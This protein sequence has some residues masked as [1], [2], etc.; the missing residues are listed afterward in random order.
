MLVV[1]L[2]FRRIGDAGSGQRVHDGGCLLGRQ[3][4][5]EPGPRS[6]R[7]MGG[8]LWPMLVP[9]AILDR[10][11]AVLEGSRRVDHARRRQR[12]GSRPSLVASTVQQDHLGFLDRQNLIDRRA[13]VGR[14][15]GHLGVGN[16]LGPAGDPFGEIGERI[17]RGENRV[18]GCEK[19]CHLQHQF[20]T[21]V[22]GTHVKREPWVFGD[23]FGCAAIIRPER[24]GGSQRLFSMSSERFRTDPFP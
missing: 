8:P 20:R 24:P 21:V 4:K 1:S 15:A 5:V 23:N 22:N 10:Q 9:G 19:R 2:Q 17:V 16:G 11:I 13:P 12:C 3:R 18:L 6:Q 7:T 14:V